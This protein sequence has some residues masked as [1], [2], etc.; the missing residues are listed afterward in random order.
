MFFPHLMNIRRDDLVLEIG[1][2]AYPHWRS[3]CLADKFDNDPATDVS[4]F[5][6][7]PQQTMGKPLFRMDGA[8][9]PFRDKSFDY[10]ICSHVLEHVPHRELPRFTAEIMRVAGRAYIEFPRPIYDFIYDFDVHLNLME[11]VGGQIVCLPKELT[12]LKD[13]RRFTRYAL[14][15]RT[16]RG[17]AVETAGPSVVAVGCE[18]LGSIPLRVCGDEEEFFR[19]IAGEAHEIGRPTL[20]WKI[21][22]RGRRALHG[23]MAKKGREYFEGLQA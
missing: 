20:A 17:F 14:E 10:I 16:R 12:R 15:L 1:P 11:I 4:Q 18:F 2:G 7:L 8:T 23:M 9:I 13:V 6:G 3:D 5:G 21:A 19:L 22:D